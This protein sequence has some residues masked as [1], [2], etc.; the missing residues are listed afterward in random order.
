MGNWGWV[1]AGLASHRPP[2]SEGRM[3]VRRESGGI[4]PRSPKAQFPAAY[5][6]PIFTEINRT[7]KWEDVNNVQLA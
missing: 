5:P 1:E 4:S 6:H 3:D 7:P 2:I